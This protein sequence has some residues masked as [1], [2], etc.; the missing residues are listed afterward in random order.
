MMGFE[1]IDSL[2]LIHKGPLKPS[3]G[4]MVHLVVSDLLIYFFSFKETTHT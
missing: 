3:I 2:P 4:I 1:Y